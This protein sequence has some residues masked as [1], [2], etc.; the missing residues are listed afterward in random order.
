MRRFSRKLRLLDLENRINPAPV[1]WTGLGGDNQWTTP[2]NW[3]GIA[4]PTNLDDVTISGAI[5]TIQLQSASANVASLDLNSDLSV[6]SS[7]L[8][9]NGKLTVQP[10]RTLS[11]TGSGASVAANGATVI[12]NANLAASSSATINLP[13][14]TAISFTG[15]ADILAQS[16]ASISF[17]N[18]SS[19]TGTNTGY[20]K[21]RVLSGGSI[22][23]PSVAKFDSG[24]VDLQAAGNGS[25][26]NASNLAKLEFT[27]S[28]GSLAAAN[29]GV[30]TL[31]PGL[32]TL[33][34][35]IA[36]VNGGGLPVGQFKT[37]RNTQLAVS[38]G[39]Q[40]FS[41]LT[42]LT[43]STVNVSGGAVATFPALTSY[44][45][46]L[47]GD[48]TLQ[49]SGAGSSL[50]FPSL[51]A[52]TGSLTS[53]LQLRALT[54]GT[55]SIPAVSKLENVNLDITVS[56][57]NSLMDFGSLASVNNPI[58]FNNISITGSSTFKTA[59][60]VTLDRTQFSF[61]SAAAGKF[62]FANLAIAPLAEVRGSGTI[63]ANVTNSGLLSPGTTSLGQLSI[64]GNYTQNATGT[65][66][67]EL[68]GL[69]QGTQYDWLNVSGQVQ[70]DGK[71][72][73]E[74][75]N[76]F[77]PGVG[78]VFHPLGY[79]SRINQFGS[80]EGLS[81]GIIDLD[82][83][84]LP[85]T[86]ALNG[87]TPDGPAIISMTPSGGISA[88]AT[89]V[90]VTFDEV[91]DPSSFDVSDVS[92]IGPSG[93]YAAT[94][95]SALSPTQMRIFVTPLAS[96]GSYTITIGPDVT[97]A[98]G[99][100]MDQNGNG[101]PGESSD[102][103][104]GT[105]TIAFPDLTMTSVTG[106][107]ASGFFGQNLTVNW[108][109]K[110]NGSGT[111]N[112]SWTDRVWLSADPILD[113]G[114]TL[115]GS[116]VIS[117]SVVP[118]GTYS[119]SMIVALPTS[120]PKPDGTYYVFVQANGLGQLVESTLSNNFLASSSMTLTNPPRVE[121]V[122][123]NH[124]AAQRSRINALTV[125]FSEVVTGP[126]PWEQAFS[127]T[128]ATGGGPVS[129]GL[130]ASPS[131]VS[132]KTVVELSFLPGSEFVFDSLV[133]GNY[134]LKVLGNKVSDGVLNLDGAGTGTP[135]SDHSFAFLRRFGDG[136][137][138]GSVNLIDF[139]LFRADFGSANYTFNYDNDAFVSLIDFAEFRARFNI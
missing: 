103:F 15:V 95:L 79:G 19:V 81:T 72:A 16:N 76:G 12:D 36:T 98:P 48:L 107:P 129:V 7:T 94:G 116:K 56:G 109:A 134:T 120:P 31:N 85:A 96:E 53:L 92:V 43:K 71:A 44:N 30:I 1:T 83:T 29:G 25:T 124:G 49:S 61:D 90:D 105:I 100:K 65:L 88:P 14:L 60:S 91:I 117:A 82:P 138:N 121:A 87:G 118:T 114:D 41:Q 46:D 52:V 110:N 33:Q 39:T 10:A 126:T 23:I 51:T 108:T 20:Q 136:D 113:I 18:L 74:I 38:S 69:T 130:S 86:W 112:G 104:S 125:T 84:F 137:G 67:I 123:V 132:G 99:N 111:A 97:D 26:I 73:V 5:G 77:V 64:N 11:V 28:F 68:G 54:G 115:L 59:A 9:I 8:Q 6:T 135:G 13:G 17:A 106:V 133:D 47:S 3:S 57:T 131:V 119:D 78:N 66:L 50:S 127:L 70:L 24:Y 80:Y 2:L 4:L 35:V 89:F 40:N 22:S 75:V 55:L 21:F 128:R 93:P 139:S 45:T 122:A 37:F 63:T 62:T 42:E 101:T 27:T 32:T 58:D 102:T 34:W